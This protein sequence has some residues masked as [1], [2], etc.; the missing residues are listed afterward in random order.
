MPVYRIQLMFK[1]AIV[2]RPCKNMVKGITKAK[3]GKPDFELA[4][5]QHDRYIE[6]LQKCG[7]E[8]EILPADEKFPDSTFIEDAALCAKNVAIITRP[9]AESRQGEEIEMEKVLPNYFDNIERIVFR[10][11]IEAGDIMMVGDHFYI[12]HSGRTNIE[13]ADQMQALLQKYGKS[14]SIVHLK[15][16]LHLK[17]GLSYLE[18]N[19]LLISGEFIKNHAFDKFNKIVVF[20]DE[21]YAANS[22]WING[23]VLVP[24]GFPNTRQK[25]EEAGYEVLQVDVSEFRKLDGGLSCLSLRF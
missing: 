12:G 25:I 17:T 15:E 2:K 18:N 8:V 16:M 21:S 10:G 4:L 13:G 22:V 6:A 3:L 20:E 5:K 24:E 23:K 9:G 14:S 11:T 19:I 7:L 1:H